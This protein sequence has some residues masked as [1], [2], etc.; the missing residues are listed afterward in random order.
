MNMPRA[1]RMGS[2]SRKNESAPTRLE[3]RDAR[4][5]ALPRSLLTT[6]LRFEHRRGNGT[7][8]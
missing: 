2:K 8:G 5:T 3:S 6:T 1:H 4:R 7:N